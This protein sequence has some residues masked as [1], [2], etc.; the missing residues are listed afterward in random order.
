MFFKLMHLQYAFP[1]RK[2][3]V[4]YS[5]LGLIPPYNS[6]KYTGLPPG[7]IGSPEKL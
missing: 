5:D 7:P 6:Y 2:S 4:L 1:E 3:R